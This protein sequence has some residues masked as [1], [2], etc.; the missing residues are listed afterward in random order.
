MV[1]NLPAKAADTRAAGLIP[2]SGR[3]PG[4]GYGNPLQHSR[5]RNS[6]DGGAWRATVHGLQELHTTWQLNH[7]HHLSAWLCLVLFRGFSFGV[8]DLVP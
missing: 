3:S 4:G 8:W 7:H 2:E 5:P 1:K 6:M